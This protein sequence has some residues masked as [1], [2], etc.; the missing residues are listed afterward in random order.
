[1]VQGIP[2]QGSFAGG[3]L[4]QKPGLKGQRGRLKIVDKGQP[5]FGVFAFE[6]PR[7]FILTSHFV[8]G[9]HPLQG[10]FFGEDN[11]FHDTQ[12]MPSFHIVVVI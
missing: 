10:H 4:G 8:K 12:G 5:G 2:A 11:N 7:E 1:M 6:N 3:G 9:T